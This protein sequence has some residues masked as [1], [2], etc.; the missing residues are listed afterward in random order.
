MGEEGGDGEGGAPRRCCALERRAGFASA[1][2]RDGLGSVRVYGAHVDVAGQV[3]QR[4]VTRRS[5]WAPPGPAGPPCSPI[6]PRGEGRKP[7]VRAFAAASAVGGG[8][9]ARGSA[10]A[11]ATAAGGT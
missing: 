4:G 5:G 9:I 6:A 8:G 2:N 7:A 11:T 10:V 1:Q 3:L